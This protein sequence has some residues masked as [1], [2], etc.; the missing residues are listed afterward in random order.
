MPLYLKIKKKQILGNISIGFNN[1]KAVKRSF[2]YMKGRGL[3]F[4]FK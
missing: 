3:R 2:G 1:N 4:E